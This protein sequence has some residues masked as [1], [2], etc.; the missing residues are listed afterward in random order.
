V[1]GYSRKCPGSP[2]I[3]REFPYQVKS[4]RQKISNLPH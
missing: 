3:G 2:L 1:A 4:A